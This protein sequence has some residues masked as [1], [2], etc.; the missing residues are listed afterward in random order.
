MEEI[1]IKEQGYKAEKAIASIYD[2]NKSSE[3][4]L[5]DL[6]E[7]GFVNS[8]KTANGGVAFSIGN[9]F[10]ECAPPRRLEK[11]ELSE[12]AKKREDKIKKKLEDAEKRRKLREAEK[13]AKLAARKETG[14]SVR[15][16]KEEKE[17][18]KK[19]RNGKWKVKQKDAETRR[20]VQEEERKSKQEK[21][22]EQRDIALMRK[23]INALH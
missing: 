15:M 12:S 5:Q 23:I 8:A 1:Q 16:K 19:E 20:N 2:E 13:R 14:K 22:G 18:E 7:A 9:T 10:P 3:E 11:L 17:N 6:A 21:K 4:I